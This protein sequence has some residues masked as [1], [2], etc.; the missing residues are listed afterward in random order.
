MELLGEITGNESAQMR[1]KDFWPKIV[2]CYKVEITG[3]PSDI[4]F[5]DLSEGSR[6]LSDLESLLRKWKNGTVHWRKLTDEEYTR[7]ENNRDEQ[8]ERREITVR[9]RQSC[10]DA[11]MK[12]RSY[13]GPTQVRKKARTTSGAV[14]QPSDD[15]SSDSDDDSNVPANS[16]AGSPLGVVSS[17]STS[18]TD[19][20]TTLITCGA[21]PS[22]SAAAA[23]VIPT[24]TSNNPDMFH[25]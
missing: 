17:T 5:K 24:D 6:S 2:R 20:A 23:A 10:S 11:G 22:S 21:I 13:G 3:W 16:T 7:R 14:I 1:Y 4:P 25:D 8:I 18:S 9:K 15:E 19:T 12:R